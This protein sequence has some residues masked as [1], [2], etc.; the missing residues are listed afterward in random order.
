MAA[1]EEKELTIVNNKVANI[2]EL[3]RDKA[4]APLLDFPFDVT[5]EQVKFPLNLDWSPFA[6]GP[7]VLETTV[8]APSSS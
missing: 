6:T 8:E 3:E 2:E 7:V 4:I 5:C 1:L